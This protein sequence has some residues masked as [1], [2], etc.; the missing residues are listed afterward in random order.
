MAKSVKP[1]QVGYSSHFAN[2]GGRFL[3]FLSLDRTI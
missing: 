1:R 2:V 3:V